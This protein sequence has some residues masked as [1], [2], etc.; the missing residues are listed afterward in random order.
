MSVVHRVRLPISATPLVDVGHR[1]EP[2]EVMATRRPI[3]EGL[4]VD[5]AGGLRRSA[6]DACDLLRVPP[7]SRM[8]AGDPIAA[9]RGGREVVAPVDCLFLAYDRRNGSALIAPLE[10]EVTIIGHVRGEV[11]AVS[12]DVIEISVAGALVTGIG[13][14]GGAVHGELLMAVTDP[15]DELR[16]G[17]IDVG[18]AG[19]ILVGGSRASAE[20]LTRARAMGVAGIVLGGALDKEL[21]DFEAA[22]A[23]RRQPGAAEGPAV[24]VVSGYG[25]TALE[26]GLFA[27]F[28]RHEGRLASLFGTDAR[29]YV[30]D[31]DPPP[32]R[33]DLPRAG[34]RVVAERR[35]YA[36]VA[37]ELVTILPEPH[38][39]PAGVAVDSGIVRF[40]DG[41][42]A[43]VPL[44][45]LVA[46]ARSAGG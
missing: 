3:G 6:D 38:A 32:T 9:D 1:V 29:L 14:L 45:N 25:R 13:G 16:A 10:P 44:A 43:V 7:G 46:V 15:A 21:R 33:R 23:R 24:M 26:G 36:G 31:A 39:T 19:R 18:A 42:T 30:Y 5:V 41:R 11:V 20:T 8:R 28:A 35:P 27:W 12:R 17:A 34:D 37:G 4:V 2:A 22:H 40:D